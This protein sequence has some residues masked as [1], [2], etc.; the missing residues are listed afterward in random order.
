MPKLWEPLQAVAMVK[1]G[2]SGPRMVREVEVKDILSL[3]WFPPGRTVLLCSAV[4]PP[5]EVT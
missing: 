1:F 5:Q 3:A 4:W 2:G